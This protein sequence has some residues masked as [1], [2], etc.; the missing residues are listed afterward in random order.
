MIIIE[1][2]VTLECCWWKEKRTITF[3]LKQV[4]AAVLRTVNLFKEFLL[5]LC[6]CS[7]RIV[8]LTLS[9]NS[10]VE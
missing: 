4:I 2:M 6:Y 7:L 8:S 3:I 9:K 1:N 10:I 5:K